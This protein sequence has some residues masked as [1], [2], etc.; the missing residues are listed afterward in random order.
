MEL[1][2]CYAFL[3]WLKKRLCKGVFCCKLI[4]CG[5]HGIYSLWWW[6]HCDFHLLFHW[7]FSTPSCCQNHVQ[8][9]RSVGEDV[10]RAT[11][12]SDLSDL[13][14]LGYKSQLSPVPSQISCI[15]TFSMQCPT[16]HRQP[17]RSACTMVPICLRSVG[18][19][20]VVLDLC[21][22]TL[23]VKK[24]NTPPRGPFRP[25]KKHCL[26]LFSALDH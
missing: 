14:H 23:P 4:A 6:P 19:T 12:A 10:V 22:W 7:G 3:E 18:H 17:L 8:I 15:Y 25:E 24:K 11:N 21:R 26:G 2:L 9:K 5:F 13:K 1:L 20:D 16:D